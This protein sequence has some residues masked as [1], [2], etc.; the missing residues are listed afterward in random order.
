MHYPRN[1]IAALV[2]LVLVALVARADDKKTEYKYVGTK[3]CAA[4]HKAGKGGTAYAV[5]EKGAHAKAYKTL[6]GDAAKKIAKEKGLKT[7]PAESPECLK[8]HVPG[9][10]SAKNVEK[11]FDMKEGVTCEVCHGAASGY[12]MIHSKGDLAKS[13]E[14]GLMIADKTGKMCETCH[15]AESPT[16]KEF[17]FAE[18][19]KKIEH[20]L[21]PKK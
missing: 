1:L 13:K 12:K 18:M 6:E 17:K 14:S 16:N 19:W 10:G 2:C 15:N 3:F 7:A 8:C 9:G 5:W 11:T 4:C 20:G 21:P